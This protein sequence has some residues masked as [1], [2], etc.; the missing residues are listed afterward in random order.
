MMMYCSPAWETLLKDISVLCSISIMNAVCQ[1]GHNTGKFRFGYALDVRQ[2][3][4]IWQ[5]SLTCI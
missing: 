4:F 1:V 5:V 3:L 2:S